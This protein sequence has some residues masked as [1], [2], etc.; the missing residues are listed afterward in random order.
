MSVK[1]D[2]P[3]EPNFNVNT[4]PRAIVP[5]WQDLPRAQLHQ[6]LLPRTTLRPLM[7]APTLDSLS[8]NSNNLSMAHLYRLSS[9]NS[10]SAR[11]VPRAH[12]PWSP[13]R[14]D[15]INQYLGQISPIL[16]SLPRVTT[17]VK[18]HRPIPTTVATV[19]ISSRATLIA[20]ETL[21]LSRRFCLRFRSTSQQAVDLTSLVSR[22][23][24]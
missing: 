24:R 12:R 8:N 4:L 21:P 22:S 19:T 23:T 16:R 13:D 10:P 6:P 11:S 5:R 15:T 1:F 2:F 17:V 7:H 14:S 20:P 3:C 18:I 9:T